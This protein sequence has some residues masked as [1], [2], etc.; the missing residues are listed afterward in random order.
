[1]DVGDPSNFARMLALYDGSR[2]RMARDIRGYHYDDAETLAGM[3]EL[4]DRYGYL[5]DPHTAVAYLGLMRYLRDTVD[6][7]DTDG[8]RP[9]I[10]LATAHPAKFAGVWREALGEEVEL[11][12]R[13]RACRARPKQAT[14][15][16]P[17]DEA[18][19]A[20]LLGLGA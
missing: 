15:L 9:G 4:R 20:F 3:R 18:L 19:R 5:A 8:A 14:R 16:P 11:P 10:V 1:M 12:E 7:G 6:S 2:E 17:S 13:L